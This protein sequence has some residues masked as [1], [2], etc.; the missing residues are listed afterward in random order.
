MPISRRQFFRRFLGPDDQ[1]LQDRKLRVESLEAF[2]RSTLLPYDFSL[3]AQQTSELFAEIQSRVAV[4]PEEEMT[5]YS[6]PVRELMDSINR[7]KIDPWRDQRWAA[8]EVRKAA[9]IY[10]TE[11]LAV[12]ASPDD[13]QQLRH[14]FNIPYPTQVEE[15]VQR[16]AQLWLYGL[17]DSRL[18]EY[19]TDSVRE[20]VF[21]EL[22]AWC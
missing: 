20:L 3:D 21:S 2:L 13:L 10:V 12:E 19:T 5:S 16:Q 14:R 15:E 9:G 17:S 22:R 18:A 4:L 11:F 7:S 8:D 6:V 1:G